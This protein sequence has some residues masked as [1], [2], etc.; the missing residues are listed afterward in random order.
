[1][2]R[3]LR[4]A[5]HYLRDGLIDAVLVEWTPILNDGGRRLG[6]RVVTSILVKC[7]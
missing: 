2:I 4:L 5:T 3:R 1:M 6:G 7:K